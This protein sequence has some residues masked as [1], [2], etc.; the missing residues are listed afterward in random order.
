MP[1]FAQSPASQTVN[2]GGNAAFIVSPAQ[3]Y[4]GLSYQWRKNGTP[5]NAGPTGTGSTIITNGIDFTFTASSGVTSLA[6]GDY[7]LLVK[8]IA[9][10][11]ARYGARTNIGGEFGGSLLRDLCA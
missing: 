9:A 8:N 11:T 1:W 3:G 7:V 5:I 2:C 6:P 10:F 4:G